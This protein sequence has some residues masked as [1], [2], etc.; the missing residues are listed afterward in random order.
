MRDVDLNA[1]DWNKSRAAMRFVH[2]AD[3]GQKA[4]HSLYRLV[5]AAEGDVD[6]SVAVVAA[7]TISLS[8]VEIGERERAT[9]APFLKELNRQLLELV[10]K[11]LFR[12]P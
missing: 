6:N 4:F 8:G 3:L 10:A 2:V 12:R 7:S 11:E 1:L 5:V 9:I